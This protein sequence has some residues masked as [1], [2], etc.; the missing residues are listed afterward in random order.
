[1]S[2]ELTPL[3]TGR[4]Y[5]KCKESHDDPTN[6]V[7]LCIVGAI[8]L[9]LALY[10]T[11]FV[12]PPGMVGVVVT[13]GHVSSYK[14]GL[15]WRYPLVSTLENFSAKTQ[16][17]EELNTTPTKE[18]LSVQLATVV[19]FR[20]DE[21]MVGDLYTTVGPDFINTLLQ[22]EANSAVRCFTSDSEAKDL[23]TAGRREIQ[24]EL[25]DNL[26]EKLEPRGI[27]IEDVLLKDLHLPEM[28]AR[29]IELK[30]ETE[31]E[32]KQM[33]FVLEKEQQEA[34][35]KA[36]EAEGIAAFQHIVSEGISSKLLQWK[37]IEATEMLAKSPNAK[38]VVMGNGD[39]GLPVLLS[40]SEQ[41]PLDHEEEHHAPQPVVPSPTSENS[42]NSDD[43]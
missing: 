33:V 8:I 18:G 21:D 11:I 24:D 12:V 4:T 43:L 31:Q 27:I 6:K 28:L 17:L 34:H 13:F 19:L 3:N 39:K 14:Q 32:A 10:E 29:S 1:M 9:G 36:I 35:R 16:K 5:T 38:L 30:L 37:G 7:V 25:K 41:M 23:Y 26:S 2:D 42:D 20:L 15:H 22:P 40:A